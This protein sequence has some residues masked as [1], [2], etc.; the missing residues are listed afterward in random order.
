MSKFAPILPRRDAKTY[1]GIDLSLS[2]SGIVILDAD[3]KL[4]YQDVITTSANRSLYSRV[5]YIASA[6]YGV[7]E[8]I[9]S[10]AIAAIEV[11]HGGMKGGTVMQLSALAYVIRMQF[12]PADVLN[13]MPTQV[14]QFATGKGSAA[15]ELMLKAVYQRWGFDTDDN[16]LADAYALAQI[17]RAW[18]QT[19]E[20]SLQRSILQRIEQA[21]MKSLWSM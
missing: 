17:A 14:K 6:I 20:T 9:A 2:A 19:G 3:G 4:S 11:P 16:N 12:Y 15:K 5:E 18:C 7:T 13:V 10:P 8:D 21:H 1:V